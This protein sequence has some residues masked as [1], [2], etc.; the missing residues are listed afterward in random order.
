M[1]ILFSCKADKKAAISLEAIPALSG[2]MLSKQLLLYIRSSLLFNKL[3][4]LFYLNFQFFAENSAGI[5]KKFNFL[6]V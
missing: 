2:V 3:I 5:V 4:L 6:A 1:L